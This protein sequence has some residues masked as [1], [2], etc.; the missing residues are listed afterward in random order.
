MIF[1]THTFSS[2]CPMVHLSTTPWRTVGGR[3]LHILNSR[4]RGR[5]RTLLNTTKPTLLVLRVCEQ[6]E[7]L[8]NGK[9][10]IFLFVCNTLLMPQHPKYITNHVIHFILLATVQTLSNALA[11]G[12][13]VPAPR[14]ISAMARAKS[15]AVA[16][17]RLVTKLSGTSNTSFNT[18]LSSSS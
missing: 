16:G 8:T 5:H 10:D 6:Q 11:T 13:E 15:K 18:H 2:V 17:P 12:L 14:R 1:I 9:Q 3:A 4:L 7:D